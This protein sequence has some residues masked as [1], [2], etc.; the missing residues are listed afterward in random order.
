MSGLAQPS[1]APA[2][3][4]ALMRDLGASAYAIVILLLTSIGVGAAGRRGILIPVAVPFALVL[5]VALRRLRPSAERWAWALF[6]LWLGSTYLQSGGA[7]ERV[8]LAGYGALALA[9]VLLNPWFLVAAWVAHP[10]WDLVPHSLPPVLKDL[11][12]ACLGFDWVIA[13]YLVTVAYRRR[14]QP[15][16]SRAG[17]ASS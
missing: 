17:H 6:T 12:T 15:Q 7:V 11:P 13:A 4:R 8:I 5:I 3:S 14:A 10:L 2:G 1:V 16:I 9:G